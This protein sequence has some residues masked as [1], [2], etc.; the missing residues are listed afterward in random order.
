ME[1]GIRWFEECVSPRERFALT[2]LRVAFFAVFSAVLLSIVPA[3]GAGTGEDYVSIPI[4]TRVRRAETIAR[5]LRVDGDGRDWAGIPPQVTPYNPSVDPSRNLVTTR[6]V[7]DTAGLH[8]CLSTVGQPS[9][10]SQTFGFKLDVRGTERPDVDF[11]GSAG[12]DCPEVDYLPANQ[13]PSKRAVHGVQFA[14]DQC[15]EWFVPWDSLAEALPEV[16]DNIAGA[17][18][19]P[20]IRVMPY[21]YD[22]NHHAVTSYGAAAACLRL[23]YSEEALNKLPHEADETASMFS[24]IEGRSYVVCGAYEGPEGWGEHREKWC[25]DLTVMDLKHSPSMIVNSRNNTEYY[26]YGRKLIAPFDG[27]VTMAQNSIIDHPPWL[28]MLERNKAKP[29]YVLLKYSDKT[30]WFMHNRQGSQVPQLHDGVSAGS[31]IARIGDS[32]VSAYPHLHIQVHRGHDQSD[33]IPVALKNVRI[34]LN[35]GKNDY[36]ARDFRG[37]EIWN[38][39]E[40]FFMEALTGTANIH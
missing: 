39:Q 5:N 10:D 36:W 26:A 31:T 4:E 24:M 17:G 28:P 30:L 32:G 38:I 19:R 14:V 3:I 13:P 20:W 34:S 37:S 35:T 40:G 9:R 1:N 33:L 21:S 22:A 12:S 6:V 16:R 27:Q 8:V 2:I 7:A 23:P 25:Y 29:N 11:N 15:V 18:S